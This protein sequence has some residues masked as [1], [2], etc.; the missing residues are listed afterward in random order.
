MATP[1]L[2]SGLMN[3]RALLQ[4]ELEFHERKIALCQIMLAH[5]DA[6]LALYEETKSAKVLRRRYLSNR[7]PR[8]F[9]H[10]LISNLVVGALRDAPGPLSTSE[11]FERVVGGFETSPAPEASGLL[12]RNVRSAIANKVR[13]G[14]FRGHKGH[15]R[16]VT[17]ELVRC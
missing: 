8:L 9:E 1:L 5:F 7:K 17:Y 15:G 14:I 11:I 12:Y 4:A 3:K 2:I 16:I 10:G 6:T 13:Q